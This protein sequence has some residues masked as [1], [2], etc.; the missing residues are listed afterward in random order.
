MSI[1]IIGAGHAAAQCV[2]NIRREGLEAKITMIGDEPYLPYMRPPLSKAFLQDTQSAEQLLIKPETFYK[3]NNVEFVQAK[4]T[5]INTEKKEVVLDKGEALAYDKLVVATGAKLR[6]LTI[7]GAD[8]DGVYYLKTL[9]EAEALKAA[10]QTSRRMVVC[11]GGYIGLEV[12]ASARQAGLEVT[13]IEQGERLMQ[14][15]VSPETSSYYETLHKENGVS[16][17]CNKTVT[18][19]IGDTGIKKVVCADGEE[20]EADLVVVGIG[21]IP[22]TELAETAGVDIDN[23]ITVNAYCQTNIDNIYAMGDCANH[24]NEIYQKNLRLECVQ[25]ANGQAKTIALHLAEKEQAYNELPWFWSDQYQVKLQI[26]GISEG[27]DELI[28][29]HNPDNKA[30]MTIL[31]MKDNKLIAAEVIANP[32][33]FLAAKMLIAKGISLDKSLL[34]DVNTPLNTQ[35]T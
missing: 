11:G 23:G 9:A 17:R 4:A 25:N 1:V 24:F 32:K 31:A 19:F 20:F 8:L 16:I 7:P 27:Y 21:V 26:A 10:M 14:R 18:E 6:K 35:L 12:A 13:V 22:E 3:D 15:V 28:V 29:R 33:D 2:M 34:Q 30:A 5:A